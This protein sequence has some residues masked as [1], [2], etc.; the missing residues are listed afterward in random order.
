MQRTIERMESSDDRAKL[1][2]SES[3]AKASA[4]AQQ[5]ELSK[6]MQD[7]A[8][9]VDNNQLSQANI[10]QSKAISLLKQMT[11]VLKDHQEFDVAVLTRKLQ[12]IEEQLKLIEHD[13]RVEIK[14]LD[15]TQ[16]ISKL[17]SDQTMLRRRTLA[18][19]RNALKEDRLQSVASAIQ[20]V[21]QEQGKAILAIR[22][23]YIDNARS[24]EQNAILHIQNALKILDI[25]SKQQELE[26]TIEKREE[27]IKKYREAAQRENELMIETNHLRDKQ[28]SNQR[29]TRIQLLNIYK[30]Q[31][32][33]GKQIEDIEAE[34]NEFPVFKY[35]HKKIDHYIRSIQ[36]KLHA[37]DNID[38]I[39]Y[40]QQSIVTRLEM[41]ADVLEKQNEESKFAI[42]QSNSNGGDGDGN[43]NNEQTKMIPPIA[44][45][46]LLRQI[47]LRV[48]S[49]TRQA[50][51]IEDT[52]EK[53][54]IAEE[55]SETQNEL[56]MLAG[57][58]LDEMKAQ[59][60]SKDLMQQSK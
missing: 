19:H 53:H 43:S 15:N 47:Q 11:G 32:R 22:D 59:Q 30:K 25:I 1:A 5:Q 10:F 44:Q 46:R 56:A 4:I 54:R 26:K 16:N 13:Q 14:K 60:K 12:E 20:E 29:Q 6:I 52:H 33:I 31:E 18:V 51:N 57:N 50:D 21:T 2:A 35:E 8:Q 41:L 42:S 39:E 58:M 28:S 3:I 36:E 40:W 7:A 23:I 37:Y 49:E 34:I 55:L 38:T 27:L 45:L 9:Q 17:E 48:N 24:A